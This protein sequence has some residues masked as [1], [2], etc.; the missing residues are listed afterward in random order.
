M[1][2]E[3]ADR[4]R[5]VAAAQ[6]AKARRRTAEAAVEHS[7]ACLSSRPAVLAVAVPRE[8]E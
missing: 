1:G 3:W 7:D 8:A 6:S 5:G 2:G 4:E